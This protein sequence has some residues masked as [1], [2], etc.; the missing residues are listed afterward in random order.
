MKMLIVLAAVVAASPALAQQAGSGVAMPKGPAKP[1]P[2][3]M[4][5]MDM[6]DGPAQPTTTPDTA[7]GPARAAD[8][9]WDADAMRASRE[10]LREGMGGQTLGKVMI[11]R[12]E[13][14]AHDGRDGYAWE[15]QVWY[16]GDIDKLWIKSEG[17]GTFGGKAE[18][19]E[20]QVLWSHAVGPWF[21]VQTGIRHDF[22]GPDR[23]H[24]VVGVQGLLPYEFEANA[25][26]FLSD[27]GDLT[28]R[29][30]GDVDQRITQ[31]LIL[32]PR[33]ELNLSAQDIREL[34][35]GAGLDK[36]EIGLRLRYEFAREFAPYIGISHGWRGGKS[37][38]YARAR[39]DDV[40]TTNFVVGLRAWF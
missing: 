33:A 32:Q 11:D 7:T 13:Y 40:A 31:R 34:G 5:H 6:G 25:A 28:A 18:Q 1:E 36:A 21:D 3:S 24:V 27:K 12:L 39:R 38:D 14:Q 19:A 22:A 26:I 35:V 17:E 8:A 20:V 29:V 4:Q 16:G 10:E 9:V 15:G 23:S 30:E 37:A 2:M